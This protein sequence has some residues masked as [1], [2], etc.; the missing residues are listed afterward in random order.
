MDTWVLVACM[1]LS[2]IAGL[3]VGYASGLTKL[4]AERLKWIECL[5][6]LRRELVGLQALA[7]REGQG[8]AM[9]QA[10]VMEVLKGLE[11]LDLG[12]DEDTCPWCWWWK[13]RGH[14]PKCKLAAL[15]KS[16]GD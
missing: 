12:E 8:G 15:L 5:G 11:W 13:S 16:R 6:Y 4:N 1:V 9:D 2:F 3:G 10:R 7:E 14:A